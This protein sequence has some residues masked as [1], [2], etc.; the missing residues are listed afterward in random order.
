MQAARPDP[1]EGGNVYPENL[2]FGAFL[3]PMHPMGESPSLQFQRDLEL[4]ELLDRLDY[5]EFW[6]GEHHSMGWNTIGAPE[7]LV[8]AAAERTRRITLAT[9]VMTLPYHHPF[10]VASRAVHLDHLTRGR[11]VL[12]VGA[13][14]IPTDA[15]MLGREMAELRASFAE[16]LAAVVELVNGDSRVTTKTP[17]FTLNDAKLQLAPYRREGLEIVAASV[18]SPNS[19][20]LAGRFGIST[21]SFGA[22]R[23]GHPRPD[24]KTQWA[25]A[26]ESA[27]EHGQ[28]VDRS[29]WRITLPVYVAE[30]RAEAF[31]DVR[32]GFDR[33]AYGYWRDIRGLD[34]D[35]EGVPRSRLLD[36]SVEA[37][38]AIVGSVD[39][40]VQAIRLLQ[41]ETG[42]FGTLLVY[43][44]D[45]TS[46]EKTKRSY[47]LLARYV[48]PQFTG[49]TKR[50]YESV[51]WYQD[52]RELFP[53]LIP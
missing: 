47:D 25:Y 21:V 30:S 19:M 29:K 34:V 14:G 26:E 24:M 37:G 12:G 13:G 53:Q 2:R 51:Q 35:V 39:D 1:V 40:C 28:S 49:S 6:I 8:A 20:K 36:S 27:A 9:G 10:M 15:R 18:A 17:W 33:W 41:E 5:D 4:A 50:L 43:A 7:L 31:A 46:W 48:A 16:S 22:P 44:Q 32:E 45:W 42:G 11:F 23:P 38:G 52:N 3:S